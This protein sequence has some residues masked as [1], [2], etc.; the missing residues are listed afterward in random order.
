[1]SEPTPE[2]VLAHRAGLCG[3]CVHHRRVGNRRGSI[4][5][6]CERS[7]TDARYPK[8]PPLPVRTCPGFE[9]GGQDPYERE[10][11]STSGNPEGGEGE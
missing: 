4:F 6:M 3:F 10:F 9:G 5:W 1:M 7:R 2:Q 11:G 8:Y